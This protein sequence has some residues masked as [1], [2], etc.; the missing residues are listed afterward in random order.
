[1]L[2][3]LSVYQIVYRRV[4]SCMSGSGRGFFLPAGRS[5]DESVRRE[6]DVLTLFILINWMTHSSAPDRR[7]V[8]GT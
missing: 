2:V 4:E 1:M 6:Y 7:G 3:V 8:F 5:I